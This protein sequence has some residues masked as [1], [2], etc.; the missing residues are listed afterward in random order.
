MYHIHFD[1]GNLLRDICSDCPTRG[2]STITSTPGSFHKYEPVR[3][4][5]L[6]QL[7][8]GNIHVTLPVGRPLIRPSL[9]TFTWVCLTSTNSFQYFSVHTPLL[10]RSCYIPL[11]M[12]LFT[13]F[14]RI[15]MAK[16][17]WISL[18]ELHCNLRQLSYNGRLYQDPQRNG[19]QRCLVN[20]H[21][22]IV[23]Q[24]T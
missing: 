6:Q 15:L 21:R 20:H 17:R 19:Y 23:D 18:L 16:L 10:H 5:S 12:S 14:L 8:N 9:P 22:L 7:P 3:R 13:M 2:S 24:S 4:I 1:L 11:T